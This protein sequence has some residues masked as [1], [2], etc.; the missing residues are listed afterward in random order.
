MLKDLRLRVVRW[1]LL[2]FLFGFPREFEVLSKRPVT[3]RHSS[4]VTWMTGLAFRD[5][6]I[7]CPAVSRHGRTVLL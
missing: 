2:F 5:D 3:T 6:G 1:L 4:A 7:K